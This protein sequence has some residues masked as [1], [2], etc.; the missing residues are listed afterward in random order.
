MGTNDARLIA[1][2]AAT[3]QPCDTFGRNGQVHVDPGMELL[4]PGEFQ[5]TSPPVVVG[6]T[7]VVGSAIGDNA[8]VAAPVGSVRAFDA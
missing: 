1:V 2:D 3:G 8:R 4:W 6:D 5:M 7:V